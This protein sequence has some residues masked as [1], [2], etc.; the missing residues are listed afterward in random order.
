[1]RS[2]LAFVCVLSVASPVAA[3][4]KG[5]I[6]VNFGAAASA[7]K[8]VTAEANF[9]DGSGELATSRVN[10]SSPTGASF[11]F[12][13]GYMFSRVLGVG[14]Q[15]TGTAHRDNA[16]LFVRIPHPRFF[17]A[18]ATDSDVTDQQLD[19]VEGGVNLSLVAAI[20]TKNTNL[21]VRFY[22]GP[23]YFRL[24]ADAIN[25][26]QYSQ[27][28]GLF[29][30]TNVVDIQTWSAEEVEE[31]AWGYHAGADLGFFFSNHF[32]IGGFARV[33]RG[34]VTFSPSE[35]DVDEDLDVKV[36]GFQAGGGLRIRF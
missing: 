34:T 33:S 35:F 29:T 21:T 24:K 12:G 30:T 28:F 19:R 27:Q 15:F 10:Y 8:S 3:Q 36:G 14:V 4:S 1:M 16:D 26:I 23:T 31:T 18:H 22:G 5:W 9:D 17:N 7:Q 11:D 6:D 25:G 2:A 32:G 13:G 20:P